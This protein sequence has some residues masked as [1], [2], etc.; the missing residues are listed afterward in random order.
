MPPPPG[1]RSGTVA[2]GAARLAY[3][4]T[5]SGRAVALLHP[6]VADRRCWA[7]TTE[8][9]RDRFRVV[10]HDRRGFGDTVYEPEAHDPVADLTAVL[11]ALG[12]ERVALVG[13]SMGGALAV[14]FTLAAPER[15]TALVLVGSAIEG[16]P[17]PENLDPEIEALFDQLDAVESAGDLDAVNDL[18]A[19]I[20]LDGPSRPRGTVG[21]EARQLF[22]AMN[23][24]ALAAVDP[25][26]GSEPTAPSAWEQLGRIEIP[27]LAVVGAHDLPHLIERADA[28]A[29]AVAR[30]RFDELPDSAHLPQLD[31]PVRFSELVGRFLDEH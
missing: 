29:A 18:E 2:H 19:R 22:L 4:D 15:V 7:A 12:L 20:W 17:V 25:G 23:G 14:E 24:R 3:D 21:G 13:N 31:D 9:L 26:P 28:I 1:E 6:G 27:V 16:A 8:A 11:D 10:A 30:G 5:G